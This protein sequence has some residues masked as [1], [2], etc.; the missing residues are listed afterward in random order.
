MIDQHATW[1]AVNPVQGCT[2]GCAYCF[3]NERGQTRVRPRQVATPAEA[4]EQLLASEV[5]APDRAVALYTWTDVMALSSSREHLHRLLGEWQRARVP[6]PLV[7]ITK[8]RVPDETIARLTAARAAGVPLVVFL[9]YSGLG[10]DIEQGIRHQD[11][12][13]NFPALSAAGIPL[14]HYW[15]PVLPTAATPEVMTGVLDLAA[16]YARC[17][18]VAGLKV[19]RA[20]LGRLAGVWPELALA[21]QATEAEGVYPRPFWEFVHSTRRKHPGYPV[22][23]ATACALAYVLRQ[24]DR[25]GI[26]G[27]EMCRQRTVC[28]AVQRDRCAA[29]APP[30]PTDEAVTAALRLRGLSGVGH[31][32]DVDGRELVLDAAV[33]ARVV[34]ALTQDLRVRVRVDGQGDDRY[35]SS[36]TAGAAP[37]IVG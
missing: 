31:R 15:R 6:N 12:A 2:K 26:Y 9:S 30:L 32:L 23:H 24:P 1:I 20:A 28:P 16:R 10:K 5:Y 8:C 34:G 35:W 29:A 18:M 19:E 11:S 4:V 37:L 27:S 13:R 21:P 33:P 17:S 22:F 14:V 25:F 3:L 7:L 36:G